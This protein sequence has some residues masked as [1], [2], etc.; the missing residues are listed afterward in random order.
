VQEPREALAV[1]ETPLIEAL[2]FERLRK[3]FKRSRLSLSPGSHSGL[4][5]TAYTQISSPIRR[6]AD[7]VTQRQFTAVLSGQPVP[8]APEELL[9]ILNTCEAAE[10][11]I[12]TLE[13]RSTHYWLL[14]FLE[15]QKRDQQLPAIVLDA[16]GNVELE[17]F[18]L[19]GKVA[20]KSEPGTQVQV[21]I[22][23]IDPAKGELKFKLD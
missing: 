4:G 22:E 8:Y 20:T 7:L 15:R 14:C 13:D 9:K 11:E 19:R 12:R 21:R 3:T 17:E 16:K 23:S 10:Q 18:Y 1:E 5:L 2:A 6:Y